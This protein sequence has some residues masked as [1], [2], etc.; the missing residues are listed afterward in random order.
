MNEQ[1]KKI[2]QKIVLGGVVM[3]E[4]KVLILQRHKNE[5]IYPNMWELPSG[6]RE[7]FELSENSLIREVREETGLDVKIV[8]PFSVFDYQIE[9]PDEIRDSTQINF[10]VTLVN[11]Q[12]VVLSEEH[13]EFAWITREEIDKY[14]ITEATK[15][16]IQEAFEI[17]NKLT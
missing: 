3:K 17:I 13:Q 16:V 5:D 4:G 7:P 14:D 12:V 6:K 8:I 10:L 15:N 9:K 2:V 11:N 1:N